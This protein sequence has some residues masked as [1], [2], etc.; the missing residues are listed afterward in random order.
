MNDSYCSF[1]YKAA[2]NYTKDKSN[3]KADFINSLNEKF[4]EELKI[5]K[6]LGLENGE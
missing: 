2:E 5:K 1:D 6:N 3:I 4:A